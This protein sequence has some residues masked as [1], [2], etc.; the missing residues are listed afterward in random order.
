MPRLILRFLGPPLIELD[1]QPIHLGRHKAVALLAYLALTRQ[2]HSRDALATLLWPELDQSHAR[3]QLRRTLS[4]LNGTL[5]EWWLSVD[6]ETAAWAAGAEAWIDVDALRERLAACTAHGHPPEQACP[7]C[8]PLLE[9]AVE[10]YRDGFLAGFTLPDAPA[11]DEWQ[12]FEGEGLREHVADALQRLVRW[13]DDQGEVESA[14][15]HAR[16]WL[17]MDPL[18]EPA[19]RELMA[20]YARSGQRAAALRQYDECERML[21]E[22]LGVS[23]SPETT[24]LYEQIRD[25]QDLTGFP[26]PVTQFLRKNRGVAN[27]APHLTN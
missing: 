15:P 1:G 13:Y 20:L 9:E 24:A 10:L 19:H 8:V 27:A 18:H 23:P 26:K 12:F 2:P 14:I 21:D 6:R 11:F 4:L 22:E 3:G 5:V 17:A 7:D 16:R 25:G